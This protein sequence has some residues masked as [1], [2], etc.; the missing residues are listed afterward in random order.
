MNQQI[1][2]SLTQEE[3]QAIIK[4]SLEEALKGAI[5]YRLPPP[6]DDILTIQEASG[7]LNLA[8][9]TIYEKTAKRLIPFFKNGRKLYFKKSELAQWIFKGKK[10]SGEGTTK[11]IIRKLPV[12]KSHKKAA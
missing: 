11:T 7:F 12:L 6:E 2:T 5:V 9:N 4:S 3:L 10:E 1:T 8:V